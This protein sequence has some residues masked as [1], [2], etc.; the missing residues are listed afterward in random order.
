MLYKAQHHL[1]TCPVCALH[2]C[3]IMTLSSNETKN[4][5]WTDQK[6]SFNVFHELHILGLDEADWNLDIAKATLFA[7]HFLLLGG[8]VSCPYQPNLTLSFT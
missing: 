5:F 3:P 6:Q 1:Q 4:C 7:G 2:W 8:L